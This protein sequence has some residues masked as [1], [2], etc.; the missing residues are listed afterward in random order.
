MYVSLVDEDDYLIYILKDR[1][2]DDEPVSEEVGEILR[3]AFAVEKIKEGI[4]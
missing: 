3:Y 4:K 2:G 1:S